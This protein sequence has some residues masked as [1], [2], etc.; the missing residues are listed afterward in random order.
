MFTEDD[1]LPLSA[2]QHFLFCE[3]QCALIH[4]E[5]QWD[6][7]RY[8]AEGRIMHERADT[9]RPESR[10]DLRLE[11]GVPL[12]SF[13]LGLVGK[14][15]VVEF[16]RVLK[17]VGGKKPLV[18]RWQPFPVEYKRGRPKKNNSDRV[19]LCAQAM[20][21]EEMLAVEV[22]EG[23]LFYGKT[24]R[25]VDVALDAVPRQETDSAAR[26]LHELFDN[27]RTPQPV[28]ASKCDRCSFLESCLPKTLHGRKSA[29]RY[30]K[31]LIDSP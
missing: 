5:Q 3:R 16:H 24:R 6:E 1:L 8:T 23:A 19:Q 29:V 31:S 13:R 9:G 17:T 15:D 27:R 20:C 22:P 7:N 30:L 26:K 11:F 2:L 10:R 14:A 12:R 28:Y 4:V 21:L 18:S 25:R